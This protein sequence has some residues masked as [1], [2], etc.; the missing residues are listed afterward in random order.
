M[1]FFLSFSPVLRPIPNEAVAAQLIGADWTKY[2][3]DI[4]EAFY[5]DYIFAQEIPTVSS[6]R[7]PFDQTP[8]TISGNLQLDGYSEPPLTNVRVLCPDI[9]D[10]GPVAASSDPTIHTSLPLNPAFVF[11][12]DLGPNQ[13]SVEDIRRLQE[14]LRD[15]GPAMYPEGRV[16]GT[17][18]P[19]TIAAVRR[20]QK[21]QDIPQTGI[22]GPLT[23][24]AL[25]GR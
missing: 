8:S 6:D 11:L 16:T 23:R 9:A 14:V 24:K 15:M 2:V 4:S 13:G 22:V 5:G 7:R 17:Y 21:Q 19:A 18:G 20:F 1:K 25:N 3:S 12:A 10:I